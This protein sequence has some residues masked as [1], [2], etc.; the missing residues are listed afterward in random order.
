MFD[1]NALLVLEHSILK[2]G[3]LMK[4]FSGRYIRKAYNAWADHYDADFR[5]NKWNGPRKLFNVLS[6]SYDLQRKGTKLLDLGVGTGLLS[7]EFKRANPDI[8][9]TGIDV[10][11]GMLEEC[12]K[13]KVVD[14]MVN[15]NF[16]KNGIPCEDES[17]DAV[18][19][20]GVFELINKPRKVIHEMG[21]VLRPSGA[22]SFTVYADSPMD[23]SCIRHDDDVI[24]DAL[25]EA[26]LEVEGKQR[27]YAFNHYGNDI[28]YNLYT[29]RKLSR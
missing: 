9:I 20:S 27:F 11:S 24:E 3:L 14:E 26:G 29:G 22:F 19:S 5:R 28:Y 6:G 12:R 18:V 15:A 10:S 17:F 4:V 13:K 16:E 2:M 7:A 21:R 1:I 8:H 23:Y 25:E